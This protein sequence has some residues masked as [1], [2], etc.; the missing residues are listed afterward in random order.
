M[1]ITVQLDL[2]DYRDSQ[3][4]HMGMLGGSRIP[5]IILLGASIF[6]VLPIVFL[7]LSGG[8]NSDIT[9]SLTYILPIVLI[10]VVLGFIYYNSIRWSAQRIFSQQKD[11]SKPYEVEITPDAFITSNEY[12]YSKRPWGDFRKW[13]EDQKLLLLYY[14]DVLYTPIPKRFLSDEQLAELRT[15]LSECQ[16]PDA[17]HA[18]TSAFGLSR[19]QRFVLY[20]LLLVAIGIMMYLGFRQ[21]VP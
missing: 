17:K 13:K 12:G 19:A 16:V 14:S 10:G 9:T 1:K 20:F 4:L 7:W 21:P 11:I 3:R 18:P 2:K 15:H 5:L 6:C 8:L